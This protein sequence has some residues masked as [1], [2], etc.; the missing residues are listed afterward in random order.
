MRRID[1]LI[2]GREDSDVKWRR[3]AAKAGGGV[4]CRPTVEGKTPSCI[5]NEKLYYGSRCRQ[6]RL[7]LLHMHSWVCKS[8]AQSTVKGF[9]C[10]TKRAEMGRARFAVITSAAESAPRHEAWKVLGTEQKQRQISNW[11]KVQHVFFLS[12][13]FF[14]REWGPLMSRW[15]VRKKKKT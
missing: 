1:R 11:T 12:F 4:V 9:W 3:W 7:D 5:G 15:Q 13:F 14:L 2:N 10:Q 6:T 8:E